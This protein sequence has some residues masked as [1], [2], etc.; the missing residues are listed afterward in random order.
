MAKPKTTRQRTLYYIGMR[1]KLP[2]GLGPWV[3]T[4][5]EFTDRRKANAKARSLQ[6]KNPGFKIIIAK[7]A[8]PYR[9]KS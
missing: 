6:E 4:S 7:T 3:P 9:R 2:K 1:R 8:N 5:Y